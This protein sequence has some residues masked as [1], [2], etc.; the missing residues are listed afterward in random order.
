MILL[1]SLA[2]LAM[3]ASGSLTPSTRQAPPPAYF[4]TSHAALTDA[5]TR[6]QP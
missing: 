3:T 2:L 5:W 1:A 4:Q 6:D